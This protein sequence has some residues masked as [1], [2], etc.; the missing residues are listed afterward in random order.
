MVAVQTRLRD[1][2]YYVGAIDGKAGEATRSAVMAFQ[3]V[4]HLSVDGVV[5]P[6]TLAALDDPVVPTLRGGPADRIEVDLTTQVL[7]LVKGGELVRIVPV[8]SG[9]GVTYRTKGGGYAHA[10]T[11]VGTFTI[12]RHI[13]GEHHSDLGVLISPMYFYK[14]WAIHG[15]P[16]VPAYPASHGCVRVP[17]WDIAWLFDRV[18]V[19]MPVQVYGGSHVFRV[20]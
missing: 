8:S 12:T 20:G 16:S 13:R 2:H 10:N 17:N 18:P 11:P 1:L 9:S 19:G 14:G 6:K 7:Y 5:G 3:K 4:N 15:S